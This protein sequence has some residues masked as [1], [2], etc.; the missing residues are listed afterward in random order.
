VFTEGQQSEKQK[1]HGTEASVGQ[2]TAAAALQSV[3]SGAST[4][5]ASLHDSEL[6]HPRQSSEQP[7]NPAGGRGS[8]EASD[9]AERG[10]NASSA[11]VDSPT[12]NT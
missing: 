1:E 5:Q 4:S 12:I 2:L 7:V 9:A 8:R 10:E 3:E 6:G 11:L